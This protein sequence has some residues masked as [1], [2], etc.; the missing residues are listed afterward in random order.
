MSYTHIT[1]FIV[2]FYLVG[3]LINCT[4]FYRLKK[5]LTVGDA[6]WSFLFTIVVFPTVIIALG[7]LDDFIRYIKD[8]R[9]L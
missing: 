4:G 9:I 6:L 5:Q 3:F 2:V 7:E 8:K 1:F